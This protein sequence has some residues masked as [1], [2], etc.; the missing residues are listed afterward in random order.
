MA[1]LAKV[2][3]DGPTGQ[4]RLDANRNAIASN[5][6]TEVQKADDGSGTSR[7]WSS[8]GRE[9]RPDPRSRQGTSPYLAQPVSR[10]F[11]TCP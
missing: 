3:F 4:Y 1:A 11:P 2:A 5:Y 10:D 7:T 6:V 8:Q 9:H